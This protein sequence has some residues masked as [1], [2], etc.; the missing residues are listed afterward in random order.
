SKTTHIP[1]P[2]VLQGTS[3]CHIGIA[4]YYE[5]E[6]DF[7]Y[8]TTQATIGVLSDTHGRL[9]ADVFRALANLDPQIIIHAGDICG[10]D[11]LPRLEML[12]PV[13]A[14]LGN[15]D[16]SGQY[17]SR[18]RRRADFDVLGISFTVTHITS[19]SGIPVSRVVICGHTHVP[20]IEYIGA[21]MILNPG[22]VTR[23]RGTA[24]PTIARIDLEPNFIRAAKI[25][26]VGVDLAH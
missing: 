6:L 19:N 7:S 20:K 11:I 13:V 24:G 25:I 14:V 18:V 5:S 3:P 15:N 22:S 17:G 8:L 16:Y 4:M 23:P 12:C 21:T 2:S 26:E 9:S 1:R 10:D